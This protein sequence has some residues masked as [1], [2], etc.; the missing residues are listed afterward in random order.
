MDDGHALALVGDRVL[1]RRT[2]ETLRALLRDRLDADAGGVREADLGVGL[3][4]M[5]LEQFLELAVLLRPLL[6]LD[7]G[8]DVLGV[9][10][11]DH[12]VDLL[13]R[14]HGRGDALEPAHRA[15]ADIEVEEL[16]QRDVQRADAAADGR[17]ERA[18][19]RDQVLAAGGDGLV[20]QPSVEELVGLLARVD[21]EPVDLAAAAVG[22][23]D[24]GVE[25]AHRG[26][27]DVRA[28]AV[29]FDEGDDRVCGH[30]QLAVLDAD[31]GAA[32]G[33]DEV[34]GDSRG[35]G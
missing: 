14:L 6:E 12:H 16:A 22:L 11:E 30:H 10:T 29:A 35:H 28:R 7:A 3:R 21:L 33:R 27:P 31:L 4:E 5:L 26:A 8:V 17:R 1:H 9:L 24:G 18:L 15:Q 23:G 25:D 13:R 20:R 32:G 34:D 19:D 2:E